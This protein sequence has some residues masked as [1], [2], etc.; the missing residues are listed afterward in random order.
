MLTIV[1]GVV[2]KLINISKMGRM[3]ALFAR[4]GTVGVLAKKEKVRNP[5][6]VAILPVISHFLSVIFMSQV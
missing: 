2:A 1:K 5:G 6:A 4:W 3:Y